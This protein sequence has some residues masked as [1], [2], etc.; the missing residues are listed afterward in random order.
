MATTTIA[1]EVPMVVEMPERHF[2]ALEGNGPFDTCGKQF[3]KLG[4]IAKE[5]GLSKH[6]TSMLVLCDVPHTAKEDLVWACGIL[7]T[8]DDDVKNPPND[9]MIAVKIPKGKYAT[10][11]HKGDY[12]GLPKSWGNLCMTWIPS[13]G[14]CPRKGSRDMPHYEVYLKNDMGPDDPKENL[15]TQLFCPVE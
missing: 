15:E 5:K 14:L 4:Q 8:D 13:Q 10:I 3:G 6:K 9:E 7:M 12:A 2:W 1:T 11:L